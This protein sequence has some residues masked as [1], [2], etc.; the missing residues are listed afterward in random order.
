MAVAAELRTGSYVVLDVALPGR[1]PE[2]AAVIAWT[3]SEYAFRMRRDFH[4]IADEDELEVLALAED[5]FEREIREYGLETWLARLQEW[6]SNV[7]RVTEPESIVIDRIDR[8]AD[9]LYRKLVPA[10]VQRFETHLPRVALAAAAG[11]WGEAMTPDARAEDAEEWVEVRDLPLTERMFVAR[12][13]GR[14]MEPRIPAGSDCV[15][16]D[17]PAGS[18]DGRLVL[19]EN[20]DDLSQRYTIKRYRSVKTYDEDGQVASRRVTLEPLNPEF[21]P[22]ELEEGD[23]RILGEFVRVLD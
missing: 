9:R 22:W 13:E 11:S 19:V 6:A 20:R 10:R 18:R 3:G 14:S 17:V 23:V 1:V 15:F 2:P 8:T 12:V 21:S 16:R 7:F 5:Q 4:L